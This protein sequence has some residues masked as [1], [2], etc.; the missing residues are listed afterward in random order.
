[1]DCEELKKCYETLTEENKMLEE[2]L[3]ELKSMKTTAEQFN[4]KPLQVA[5]LTVCPSCKKIC[6]GRRGDNGPSHT[7]ALLLSPK[8]QIHFYTNS[9]YTFTQSSATI[10]S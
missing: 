2:E 4:Y 3:R 5:G 8:A 7:T 9:K 1:M 10:A 6:P